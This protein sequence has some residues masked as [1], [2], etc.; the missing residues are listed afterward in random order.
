[1]EILTYEIQQ[2]GLLTE[3]TTK[4]ENI[5]KKTLV[6]VGGIVDGTFTFGTGIGAFLT[7][8]TDL[9]T[10]QYPHMT[11]DNMIMLYI[12]AIWIV[13]N[14]NADK[15]KLLL[16]KIRERKLTNV[17]P[18]VVD[19]LRSTEEI[20]LKVAEEVGFTI[21]SIV[22][23]GAFTFFAFPILDALKQL[24]SSGEITLENGAAYLKSMLIA[25]GV[26]AVKNI[27]NSIIKR[28]RFRKKQFG[29]HD[30]LINEQ[31]VNKNIKTVYSDEDVSVIVPIDFAEL[32]KMQNSWCGDQEP[33][34]TVLKKGT[35]YIVRSNHTGE[36][37][38]IHDK[39]SVFLHRSP[40]RQT[41]NLDLTAYDGNGKWIPYKKTLA[42]LPQLHQFF[43]LDYSHLEKMKFGMAISKKDSEGW[44]DKSNPFS[45]AV[46]K[47]MNGFE[48]SDRLYDFLADDVDEGPPP[49]FR[50]GAEFKT[51]EI[52]EKGVTLSMDYEAYK[53]NVVDIGDDDYYF[54]YGTGYWTD[55]PYEELD[56]EELNYIFA[57]MNEE[58]VRKTK[59]ILLLMG[60]ELKDTIDV[61]EEGDWAEFFETH[62][63]GEFNN[64]SGDMLYDLGH[65]LGRERMKAIQQ[66]VSDETTFS[67]NLNGDEVNIRLSYAQLLWIIHVHS[68]R[69]FSELMSASFNELGVELNDLWYDTYEYDE[70]SFAEVNDT[71]SRFLDKILDIKG[72]SLKNM[73]K[74]RGNLISTL[75]KLGFKDYRYG[76]QAHNITDTSFAQRGTLKFKDDT[77]EITILG[78]DTSDGSIKF[79]INHE[80]PKPEDNKEIS[81]TLSTL[82]DYVTT[83]TLF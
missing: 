78:F 40:N 66:E 61:W 73:V 35:P 54:D 17:L 22:D 14:R 59:E 11:E 83:D 64:A 53:H 12:T 67:I 71:Y 19:F 70:E 30:E 63:E 39:G 45:T 82:E 16:N 1:M 44:L 38:I 47:V 9:L 18:K 65:G 34:K 75:Q 80:N 62:F 6:D 23:V 43:Q 29:G 79:K 81:G 10:G 32:C 74:N 69:N 48:D 56:E 25:V 55:S 15:V 58:N 27:F 77:R 24:I 3:S 26:L 4:N 60:E 50:G 21:S 49:Y 28:L 31:E 57:Y 5:I 36:K 20:A 68:V 8:V 76:S 52:D 33:F 41:G 51:V 72:V 7:P 42:L 37:F 46:Y 2:I 13:S